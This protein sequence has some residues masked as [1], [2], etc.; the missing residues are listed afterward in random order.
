M[1]INERRRKA[2]YKRF[3]IVFKPCKKPLLITVGGPLIAW[4]NADYINDRTK[5]DRHSGRLSWRKRVGLPH[6]VQPVTDTDIFG[7]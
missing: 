7:T 2:F 3:K 1:E 5:I 6:R 4:S